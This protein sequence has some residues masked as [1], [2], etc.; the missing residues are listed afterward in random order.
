M[1]R[2]P[3]DDGVTQWKIE[4]DLA[5]FFRRVKNDGADIPHDPSEFIR[6]RKRYLTPAFQELRKGGIYAYTTN[7]MFTPSSGS[8]ACQENTS[9]SFVFYTRQS[10]DGFSTNEPHMYLH[11]HFKDAADEDLA[12]RVL[13]RF[14]PRV[15]WNG[16]QR[17]C[18][19]VGL[20][21]V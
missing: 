7:I 18:I 14:M 16:N 5:A 1:K 21:S 13:R 15:E 10:A 17:T 11:F 12:L 20:T 8:A 3:T 2:V 19:L 4:K 9:G 6:F